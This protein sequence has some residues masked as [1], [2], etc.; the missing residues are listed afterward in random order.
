MQLIRVISLFKYNKDKKF[1]ISLLI[2]WLIIY[3]RVYSNYE[4]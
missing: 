3:I 4:E 2:D 1:N